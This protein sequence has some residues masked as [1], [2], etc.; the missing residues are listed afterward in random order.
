[1]AIGVV[2]GCP[3]PGPVV[4]KAR[5][6]I[7]DYRSL[8]K[9]GFRKSGDGGRDARLGVVDLPIKE[10]MAGKLFVISRN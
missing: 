4:I 8:I 3:L 5:D 6:R 2:P 7:P 10:M 1:M 9:R